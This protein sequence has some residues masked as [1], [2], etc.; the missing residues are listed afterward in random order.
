MLLSNITTDTTI[1]KSS[2]KAT[3]GKAGTTKTT[4]KT[5]TI[6]TISKTRTKLITRPDKKTTKSTTRYFKTINLKPLNATTNTT[7][8][9]N[10]RL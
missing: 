2:T 3:A 6:K 8:C 10:K 1:T 9:G 5:I 4:G 7:K